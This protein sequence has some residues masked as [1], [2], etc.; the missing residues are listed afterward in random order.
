ML[1]K[2]FFLL[3]F[4]D[5]SL[6]NSANDRNIVGLS[7]VDILLR[8]SQNL[9]NHLL[10]ITFPLQIIQK[11]IK[12]LVLGRNRAVQKDFDSLP[13]VSNVLGFLEEPVSGDQETLH[14]S[15]CN[16]RAIQDF[17]SDTKYTSAWDCS[18]IDKLTFE[19]RFVN[20]ICLYHTESSHSIG[21]FWTGILRVFCW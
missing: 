17:L 6:F 2:N 8:H 13:D 10:L 1:I 16:Y 7:V 9:V 4:S 5:V 19:I 11:I 12:Q 20:F 14:R 21:D 15:F 18:N 3:E